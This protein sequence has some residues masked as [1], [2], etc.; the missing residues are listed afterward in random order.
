M[1][2]ALPILA[3]AALLFG[4]NAAFAAKPANHNLT[5][6]AP[7]P[8][9]VATP[10]LGTLSVPI[11]GIGGTLGNPGALGVINPAANDQQSFGALPGD[12]GSATF[13]PN[14]ALP[15]LG[16]IGTPLAPTIGTSAA[17]FNS[18]S[19]NSSSSMP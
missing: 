13:D 14:A 1:K 10:N 4:A 18:P 19:T 2:S 9:P 15:A 6:A 3:A 12:P 16:N 11:E 17:G 7:P 5:F 8:V